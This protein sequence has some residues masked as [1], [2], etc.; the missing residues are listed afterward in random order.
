MHDSVKAYLNEIARYPLLTATQEIE[1]S[2]QVEAMQA[3][4]GLSDLTAAQKRTIKRGERAKRTLINANLRLVVHL[5]KQ[6]MHRITG[7]GLE[8]MDLVQ[9]GA[10]GLTR[11]VELFDS[12]KGY[13][14]STYAY[15]WVRQAITRGID[16]KERLIRVPQHSLETI[17]KATRFQKT[18]MQQHG[19]LPSVDEM[20]EAVGVEPEHLRMLLARNVSPSSLDTSAVEDGSALVDLIADESSTVAQQECME[21]DEKAAML[22]TAL[23]CLTEAELYTVVRRYGLGGKEP[24]SMPSI[25]SED[26]VSR[27]RIR[28]RLEIAHN[29]MRFQL[30]TARLR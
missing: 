16:T 14:F 2:R 23:S 21:R 25:A 1:L 26:G 29:K 18:Y 17:Y 20:A 30:R 7:N 9:E 5:A 3:L 8:L 28:Q 22:E 11:A 4:S 24:R 6:Y 13:K 27:E 12:T 15:W 10:F 19:R